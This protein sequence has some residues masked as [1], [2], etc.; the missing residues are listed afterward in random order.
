P[1]PRPGL[2]PVSH[3]QRGLWFLHRL[4]ETGH[5]YH[6]PLAVRLEGPLDTGAL[7]AAARDVQQRHEILRTTFP[8]D[9]DGPRQY[10]LPAAEAPDPLTVVPHAGEQD[11][12]DDAYET[13]LREP[14]DLA[15]APPWR[16]TL[17]CRSPHEHTLLVVLHH[18]AADQ[19][20]IG[21]LTRDLATAYES[22]RRGE[23]PAW[24][25]LPLQ[26][27]DFTLWQRA[28]L[29]APDDPG[30]PLSRELAHWREALREAPAE[31]PLPAD[32]PGRPGAEH[33]GDAVGFDW[34][35]RLGTRLKEL[36]AARGAT[37]FMALH[38]AL[39]C[40]LSRW[41]AGTDVVVGTVTA[42]RE[43]PALEPLAGYFA[44]ALPLRLDLAG[45]P[46]FATVV[47]RA[48]TAG[49]T[50][51]AHTGAPFDRIVEAVGP[52]REPG[53]HP[54]FQ[55]MLN[56]RSGARPALRLAGL[57]ATEL[58]P[59]RS[60]AKYPLLWDVAEEA[61]GTLHGC[62]EYAT[63][64]FRRRT[65]EALLDAVRHFL[66][67]ALDRPE[68]PFTGLP[69]PRPGG[70][71]AESA[72]PAAVP[73]APMPGEEARAGEAATE[74]LLRSL[75]ATLLGR[76]SVD[77]DANFFRLGGDSILA[78]QLAARAQAAGVPV[79]PK[80]VFAHQSPRALARTVQG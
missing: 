41:G 5:A 55:V 60:V 23:A 6:V 4:E 46:G 25:P 9:G 37:T 76:D 17:L 50:A 16:V 58:P 59:H 65:A 3:A 32:R 54:L 19:Q 34:G 56:H 52:P 1:V 20:S 13:A 24:P 2:V 14:F 18:I 36:A 27:A 77:A 31:T 26:Y 57:R 51:F 66:E 70:G 43:D 22:R 42:G 48:R 53:R 72:P 30:S 73:P 7:R 11:A 63:D 62:L 69:C 45:D 33:P 68:A 29:G 38:A 49:L 15:A 67:A 21:P 10:V 39:A 71:P 28:R 75:T 44:Q 35:P 8:H 61:D 79:G 40:A 78:V 12:H 47:D 64:R 80:D 74:E